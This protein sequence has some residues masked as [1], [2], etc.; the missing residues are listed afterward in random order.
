MGTETYPWSGSSSQYAIFITHIFLAMQ[1]L[2]FVCLVG[3]LVGW[4]AGWVV[5]VWVVL[6][7]FFFLRQ[8]F[9]V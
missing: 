5:L 4:L 9:S 7:C 6:F 8:G 2:L 3:W 1:H